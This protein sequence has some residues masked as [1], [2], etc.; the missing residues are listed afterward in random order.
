MVDVS[1]ETFPRGGQRLG[2]LV[3]GLA[4]GGKRLRE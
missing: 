1:A 3:Q 4:G 2:S